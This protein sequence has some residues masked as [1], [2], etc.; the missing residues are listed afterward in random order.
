MNLASNAGGDSVAKAIADAV[1]ALFSTG[2]LW[3]LL[4]LAGLGL[5]WRVSLFFGPDRECWHCTGKG[6]RRGLL[7]GRRACESCGATGRIARFGSG[8]KK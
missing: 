8:G 1:S 3:V 4:I 7:G 2:G 5:L 6:W